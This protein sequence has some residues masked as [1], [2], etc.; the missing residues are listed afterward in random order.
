ME[1]ER[2]L[3][4]G[5]DSASLRSVCAL[6]AHF[7]RSDV[8]QDVVALSH[9]VALACHS[10]PWA[11]GGAISGCVGGDSRQALNILWPMLGFVKSLLIKLVHNG[12]SLLAK[13]TTQLFWLSVKKVQLIIWHFTDVTISLLCVNNLVYKGLA[14]VFKEATCGKQGSHSRGQIFLCPLTSLRKKVSL[15]ALIFSWIL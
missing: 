13:E 6:V 5:P 2:G 9:W 10:L 8:D 3:T 7:C 11:W 12:V 4:A 1:V 15:S 14:R